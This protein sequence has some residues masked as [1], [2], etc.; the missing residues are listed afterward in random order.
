MQA[1]VLLRALWFRRRWGSSCCE[2]SFSP[3]FCQALQAPA[4][5]Q[6]AGVATIVNP[7]RF[8]L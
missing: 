2:Q 8:A 5:C 4:S 1:P 3:T 6:N 7:F